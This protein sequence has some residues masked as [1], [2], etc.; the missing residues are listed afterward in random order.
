MD[1]WRHN[2]QHRVR[3]HRQILLF[4]LTSGDDCGVSIPISSGQIV[5]I[6]T[7][8]TTDK[9]I[10]L[11]LAVFTVAILVL[12]APQIGPTWDEPTYI[13]A[14][15]TYPAWYSQLIRH[16]VYALS[17]QGISKYWEYSHEHPPLSKVWSGFVWLGARHIFDDLTAHR[18]GNILIASVLVALLY[19]FVAR[20]YSRTAGLVAVLALLT[21]PRF[22]F[23]AHLDAIDVPVAAMIFA[24][25][26][27]FWISRN[28]AEL[29]WTLLLG[30]VWGLALATKINALIVRPI[31][32]LT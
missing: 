27:T 9:L 32:L 4:G 6:E 13:V 14:A 26:Y 23:H 15:E 17:A 2:G 11:A 31:V 25:F 22:F 12:T 18:L 24:V 29:K 7:S 20:S 8:T 16:P 10:A 28:Q 19:L 5:V 30:L 3:I 21:M 1:S